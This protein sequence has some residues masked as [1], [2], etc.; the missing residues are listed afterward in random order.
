MRLAASRPWVETAVPAHGCSCGLCWCWLECAKSALQCSCR[1]WRVRCVSWWCAC[2]AWCSAWCSSCALGLS[3]TI[4]SWQ[5]RSRTARRRAR[6]AFPSC[7]PP[8]ALSTAPT[9]CRGEGAHLLEGRPHS[10]AGG[11]GGR[12][13]EGEQAQQQ[14]AFLPL[15][16]LRM[17]R[18]TGHLRVQ[19]ATVHTE[20]ELVDCDA[21]AAVSGDV[22]LA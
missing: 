1:S 4:T 6:E 2:S 7:C 5:L 19:G 18:H 3:N 11:R 20:C 21:D 15:S 17:A 12:R 13:L 14:T 10:R 16:A 9:A 22:R 8:S